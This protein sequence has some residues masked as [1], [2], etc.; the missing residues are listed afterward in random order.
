MPQGLRPQG[1]GLWFVSA[2]CYQ[3]DSN[4]A[5]LEPCLIPL[6]SHYLRRRWRLS[7][8]DGSRHGQCSLNLSMAMEG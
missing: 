8:E 2:G 4:V 6:L 7:F 5:F 3:V 1:W